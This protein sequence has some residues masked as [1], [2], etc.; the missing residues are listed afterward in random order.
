MFW[1]KDFH[2]SRVNDPNPVAVQ[3]LLVQEFA[4]EK[5]HPSSRCGWKHKPASLD[6][7]R[8]PH[9]GTEKLGGPAGLLSKV[10]QLNN[11]Q[12]FWTSNEK[13]LTPLGIK[14]LVRSQTSGFGHSPTARIFAR[15]REFQKRKFRQVS[16]LSETPSF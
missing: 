16:Q 3:P 4:K 7:D 10:L 1:R 9:F 13:T 5:L 15:I 12:P 11:E 6:L 14:S 8:R 2:Q